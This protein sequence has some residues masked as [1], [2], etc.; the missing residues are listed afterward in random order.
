[1]TTTIRQKANRG[2]A[3]SCVRTGL[4][5]KEY[6]LSVGEDFPA[7]IHRELKAVLKANNYKRY[8]TYASFLRYFHHFI[9]F[10]LIEFTGREEPM[11]FPKGQNIPALLQLRNHG[12][13]KVVDGVVRYYRLTEA[14]KADNE[15][16]YDP[17]GVRN[18]RG[19]YI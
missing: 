2:R 16:W 4:F 15:I 7:N 19:G 3:A 5:I 11:K 12:V 14:G 6:L 1:M 13:P 18:K 8:P 17:A 9:S 10:G